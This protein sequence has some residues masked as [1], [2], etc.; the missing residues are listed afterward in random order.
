VF[1]YPD[2]SDGRPGYL[3]DYDCRSSDAPPLLSLLKRHILR[4]KVRVR[5]ATDEWK[6][7]S[8][9]DPVSPDGATPTTRDWRQGRSGAM[10][11][12]YVEGEH[13]LGAEFSQG[14]IGTRDLRA[15]GMGD[16]LLV[17]TGD[18]RK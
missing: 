16:R 4:A 6:V 11:P 1:I 13:R 2:D 8:I 9:W 12:L 18:S 14:T 10:E 5:D 3:I 15:P 17:R 7:W